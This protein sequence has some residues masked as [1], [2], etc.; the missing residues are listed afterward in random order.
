[1]VVLYPK[2]RKG[3]GLKINNVWE[4]VYI[5]TVRK[6]ILA[7]FME[8]EARKERKGMYHKDKKVFLTVHWCYK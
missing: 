5:Y 4:G 3:G 2:P 7:S 8:M 1:M 6:I